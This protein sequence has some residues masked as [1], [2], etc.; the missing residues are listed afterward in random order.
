MKTL[1]QLLL[2]S[3]L[4]LVIFS[5]EITI[6]E[7]DDFKELDGLIAYYPFNGDAKDVSGSGNHG[8]VYGANL[9]KDRFGR[10][11]SAYSFDGVDD[12]IVISHASSLDLYGSNGSYSL[13]IWA[14]AGN[15]GKSRLIE[16]WDERKQTPYPFSFQVDSG[17]LNGI[18]YDGEQV[19]SVVVDNPWDGRW[20]HIVFLV[21]ATEETLSVYFDGRLVSTQ[22][23]SVTKSIRN[24]SDLYI[25]AGVDVDRYFRGDIDDIRIVD[26]V[27]TDEEIIDLYREGNWDK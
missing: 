9:T 10:A 8:I 1:F 20:H 17:S 25:G 21:D 13:S 2:L 16:K 15:H 11:N 27:V 6:R 18:V 24:T 3:L 4:V 7:A 19:S 26:R 14:Q 22:S 5:C 23:L 12:Q